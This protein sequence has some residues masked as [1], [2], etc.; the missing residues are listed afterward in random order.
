MDPAIGTGV[1]QLDLQGVRRLCFQTSMV[2]RA[3][4]IGNQPSIEIQ[5]I[6]VVTVAV[7]A[8]VDRQIE[9]ILSGSRWHELTRPTHGITM[10]RYSRGGCDPIPVEIDDRI[11]AD[12]RRRSGEIQV[13]EEFGFEAGMSWNGAPRRA[14][15]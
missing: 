10:R 9:L 3:G 5:A 6:T 13:G 14:T 7:E 11:E 4:A 15:R 2:L 1:E 12:V 8:A